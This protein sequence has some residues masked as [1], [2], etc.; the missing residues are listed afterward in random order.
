MYLQLRTLVDAETEQQNIRILF[1]FK[2]FQDLSPF[3]STCKISL[4]LVFSL[5]PNLT[6]E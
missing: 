3:A 1:N 2:H 4:E 6:M 5:F